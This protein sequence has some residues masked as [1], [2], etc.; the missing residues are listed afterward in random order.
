MGRCRGRRPWLFW[1]KFGILAFCPRTSIAPAHP[2]SQENAPDLGA[3]NHDT[4]ITRSSRQCIQRPVRLPLL[5][6]GFELSSTAAHQP[7]G[8]LRSGQ[9][10]DPRAFQLREAWLASSTGTISESIYPF[11][12]EAM[13]AS[14]H[15]LG[16]ATKLLGYFGGA[17]SLPAQSDDPGSEDPIT[18]GVAACGEL[19]NLSLLFGVF[20]RSGAKQFRHVL[21]S[22]PVRRFGHKLMCT[23]FE[24]RS[25]NLIR[26]LAQFRKMGP[27][28]QIN[29]AEKQ[30]DTAE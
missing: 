14:T 30:I 12:V 11:G 6:E 1:G 20:G 4:A 19:V 26:T 9:S 10:N 29:I 24:E 8:W 28:I 17:K 7:T 15:G 21:F 16:V 18:G 13:E 5:I 22:L 25:S 27:A 3:A 23:A 2:F